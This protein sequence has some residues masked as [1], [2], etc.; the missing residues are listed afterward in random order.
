MGL[1]HGRLFRQVVG[2]RVWRRKPRRVLLL[3]LLVMGATAWLPMPAARAHAAIVDATPSSGSGL[4]QAPADV[5]I[6]FTEP[7]VAGPSRITVVDEDGTDVGKGPTQIVGRDR[8]AMRRGLG[9]LAPGQYEV[10]WTTLSPIDGHTLRG[11]YFFAVGS[12]ASPDELVE[13]GPL[14]SNGVLGLLGRFLALLGLTLWLGL[15]LLSGAAAVLDVPPTLWRRLGRVLP[16][17]VVLGTVGSLLG[18][19]RTVGL[20]ALPSLLGTPSGRLRLAVILIAAAGTRVGWHSR[21]RREAVIALAVVAAI[22]QAA[23]GHAAAS[24]Q[25]ILATA[26]FAVHVGA[27]GVWLGAILVTLLARNQIRSSLPVLAPAAIRAAV[28]AGATGLISASF[29]LSDVGDITST[30][31]GRTLLTKSL[32]VAVMAAIGA[33]HAS[34]R[35]RN[36]SPGR[37]RRLVRIELVAGAVALVLTA[38]ASFASPPREGDVAAAYIKGDP[39]LETLAQRDAVSLAAASGA[40]VVGLTVLPPR[41]GRVEL[42][43]QVEG[44]AAGDAVGDATVTARGPGGR[45]VQVELSPCGR[46]CFAGPADLPTSGTWQF[47]VALQAGGDAVDVT[48]AT[49][50]PAQPADDR[51]GDA[52]A[53]MEQ[54]K[55]VRVVEVLRENTD[56]R[57]YVA[58]YVFNSPNSMSWVTRGLSGRIAI[59]DRGWKRRDPDS[60][61]RAF[62][63][64]GD[65]FEWPGGF[66]RQFF[67]EAAAARVVG[68]E[69]VGGRAATIIAFVQPSFPIWYRLWID[70]ATERVLRLEMRTED[71][72]MDQRYTDFNERLTITP[73]S[74]QPPN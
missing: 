7:L 28:V 16:A 73:P 61:W 45:I 50:L 42:R 2:N 36:P 33:R 24:I 3:T 19:A 56:G 69:T 13:A 17:A 62:D 31:Y 70:D 4:P 5:A 47:D 22:A 38:L 25:P 11:S 65:G 34:K 59:G 53:A 52:I 71:H 9:L 12:R 14:D 68:S 6:R 57:R 64:V 32:A 44:A 66:Y 21:R 15:G 55:T 8:R 20:T 39:L 67:R 41:P 10:R 30:A 49:P 72:L 23:S 37:L 29:V 26:S 60:P 54:L 46:D 40:H 58:D 1:V 18:V 51:L 63:W 74:T 27:V 48:V 35:D 43:V